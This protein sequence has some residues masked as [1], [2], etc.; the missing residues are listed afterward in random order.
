M[1]YEFSD[2]VLI[3]K[4]IFPWCEF[5]AKI[6]AS[7]EMWLYEIPKGSMTG[8]DHNRATS[9]MRGYAHIRRKKMIGEFVRQSD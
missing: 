7:D 9:L 1:L 8:K 2:I 5:L 3:Y 4:N 6:E